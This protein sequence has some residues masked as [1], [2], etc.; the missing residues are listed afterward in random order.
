[1]RPVLITLTVLS[2]AA[3]ALAAEVPAPP[4]RA[5]PIAEDQARCQRYQP[6]PAARAPDADGLMK[7][8]DAPPARL[9]RAV[10]RRINGCVVPY[11]VRYVPENRDR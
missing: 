6:Q 7:P 10:N 2:L 4:T 11:I 1:M 5:K 3:P 8:T 9:E